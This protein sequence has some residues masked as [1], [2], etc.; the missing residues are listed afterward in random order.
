MPTDALMDPSSH[1]HCFSC[2]FARLI[3][4]LFHALASRRAWTIHQRGSFVCTRSQLESLNFRCQQSTL[5]RNNQTTRHKYLARARA[6]SIMT[7]NDLS[8]QRIS[9]TAPCVPSNCG[10]LYLAPSSRPVGSEC[11][12]WCAK[13][14]TRKLAQLPAWS[15]PN[16]L[17]V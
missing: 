14:I 3:D 11:W 13:T 2:L 5:T 9:K 6:L 17:V 1:I 10:R 4:W 16:A 15:M 8:K 12:W 7:T